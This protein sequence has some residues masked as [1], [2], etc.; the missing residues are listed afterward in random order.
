LKNIQQHADSIMLDEKRM[1]AELHKKLIGDYSVDKADTQK[2]LR[3]LKQTLHN[4]DMKLEQLYEDKVTGTITAETFTKLADK[5]EVERADISKAVTLLEQGAKET[6]S[7]LGDIQNWIRLIKENAAVDHV[8][9]T[10]LDT[11]IERVEIGEST[12]ENGIKTQD[13]TIIY[14]FVGVVYKSCPKR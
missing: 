7:K 10:L 4:L 9:K 2:Q 12:V 3:E 11:L 1:T 13:V 14:M 8:D 5:T 6:K